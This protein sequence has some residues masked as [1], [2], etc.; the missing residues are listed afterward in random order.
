MSTCTWSVLTRSE[1]LVPC[2]SRDSAEAIWRALVASGAEPLG[3]VYSE[4][5]RSWR[6]LPEHARRSPW[7]LTSRAASIPALEAPTL[8]RVDASLLARADEDEHGMVRTGQRVAAPKPGHV[9][10]G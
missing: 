2:L 4:P 5:A 6:E 8:R 1:K 10:I 7:S 3:I 9:A